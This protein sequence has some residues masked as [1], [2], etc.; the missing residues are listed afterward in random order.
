MERI[1]SIDLNDKDDFY[2]KYNRNIVSK[3]LIFFMIEELNFIGKN[4]KLR[5]FIN[6]NCWL[7]SNLGS[8]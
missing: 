6:N 5:V 3:S 1:L 4:D 2:E 8:Y 7:G